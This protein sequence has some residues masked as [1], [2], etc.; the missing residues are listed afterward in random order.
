MEQVIVC[1]N[2]GKTYK[3]YR[4]SMHRLLEALSLGR[5]QLHQNLHALTGINLTVEAGTSIGVIGSNGAGKSTLLK[6]LSRTSYPTEGTFDVRGKVSS[7]L[8]LGAGFHFD[9]SGHDNIYLNGS[10]LGFSREEIETRYQDIVEFSEL[11]DFIHKPIRIYSS[12]MVMRLGFS[13]AVSMDPEVLIIDEILAVGDQHFQKKCI[14]RIHAFKDRGRTILFCSHSLY[15]VRQICDRVI[16]IKDG[17]IEMDGNPIEVTN[18]YANYERKLFRDLARKDARLEPGKRA[19]RENL[20]FLT[21]A[22][23]TRAGEDEPV[24][25]VKTGDD[26]EVKIWY[27][28]PDVDVHFNLGVSVNRLDDIQC[29]GSSSLH[30]GVPVQKSGFVTFRINNLRLLAGEFTIS[31]YIADEH[32]MMALDQMVDVIE[33][34]V[35]HTGYEVGIFRGDVEWIF[36]ESKVE[37]V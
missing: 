18:E 3:I 23:L 6:I 24:T 2:L 35:E 19:R 12:G 37:A 14:D 8:E 17:T 21:R 30:E 13:V 27:E 4:Q 1:E 33:F 11:G 32:S 26:V 31:V 15:H 7:L 20:P 25:E 34:K 22:I 36:E 9:F 16:W 28:V 5:V 29:F 10:V